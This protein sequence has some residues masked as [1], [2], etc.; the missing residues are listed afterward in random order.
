MIRDP[1][2]SLTIP[3]EHRFLHSVEK[4]RFAEILLAE[5]LLAEIL[6]NP[7]RRFHTIVNSPLGIL[8]KFCWQK[9]CKIPRGDFKR[10]NILQGEYFAPVNILQNA[11]FK[12]LEC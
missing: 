8:Q 10:D 2:E 11:E 6:Q 9:F 1:N 12:F 5:I 4:S 3:N 7:Q